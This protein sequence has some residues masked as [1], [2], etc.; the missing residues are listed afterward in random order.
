MISEA[1]TQRNYPGCASFA[2]VCKE[3]ELLIEKQNF[4]RVKGQVPCLDDFKVSFGDFR[5]NLKQ[6]AMLQRTK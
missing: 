6:Q 4:C 3:W 2:S 1:I 5:V